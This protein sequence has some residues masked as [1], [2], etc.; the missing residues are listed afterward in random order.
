MI[1]ALVL[2]ASL[3]P[4]AGDWAARRG[5]AA[6]RIDAEPGNEE[7][8]RDYCMAAWRAGERK[9]LKSCTETGPEAIRELAVIIG[10]GDAPSGDDAWSLRAQIEQRFAS[11]RFDEARRVAQRLYEVEVDNEWALEAAVQAAMQAADLPMALAL[12][13][14]GEERFGG[15][16]SGYRNRAEQRL[17]SSSGRKD[18]LFMGGIMIL[19]WVSFRQARFSRRQRRAYR[20]DVSRLSSASVLRHE[21]LRGSGAPRV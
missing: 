2:F 5:A 14:R 3:Q 6:L 10:R 17:N 11:G 8:W 13:R 21:P 4:E 18:W 12:A 20:S 16:F 7:V 19:V 9:I 15:A 1:T